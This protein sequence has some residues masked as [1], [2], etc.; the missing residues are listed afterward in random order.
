MHHLD[1]LSRG[2]ENLSYAAGPRVRLAVHEV[3]SP[4]EVHVQENQAALAHEESIIWTEDVDD[5]DYVRQSVVT[6]AGTRR[7]PVSWTGTGRR[8]GYAVLRGDA[9]SGD[10]PGHFTRRVFWVKEHDRSEQPD[11]TYK[12]TAPAEAVDPRTVAP[13][14]W[15]EQTDRAW[16]AAT[17]I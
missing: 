5:F 1:L 2:S 16:D 3:Q 10:V 8:V 17:G 11:G 4:L 14:V 13:G 9:P 6:N 12:T 7:R 15:G